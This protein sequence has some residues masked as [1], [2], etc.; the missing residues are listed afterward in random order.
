MSRLSSLK[1]SRV[2]THDSSL[3]TELR[4]CEEISKL[5]CGNKQRTGRQFR[6]SRLVR[7]ARLLVS[8]IEDRRSDEFRLTGTWVDLP[9]GAAFGEFVKIMR[10]G[11]GNAR[12]IIDLKAKEMMAAIGKKA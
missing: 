7:F 2:S 3:P 10:E 9:E 5:T 4:G 12:A 1:L 8:H 6:K 11:F